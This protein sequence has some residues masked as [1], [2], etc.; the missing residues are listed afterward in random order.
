MRNILTKIKIIRPN[1]H[2]LKEFPNSDEF[3]ILIDKKKLL[4]KKMEFIF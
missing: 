2:G 3:P 1:I 4:K